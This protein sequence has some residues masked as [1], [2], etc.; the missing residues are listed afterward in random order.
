TPSGV[1]SVTYS[2]VTNTTGT[3]YTAH[4]SLTAGLT[5]TLFFD[6]VLF[7]TKDNIEWSLNFTNSASQS[8]RIGDLAL[9]FPMNTSF[10]TPSTSAMKHSFISG[11]GSYIFWMRPDSVG[12]CLLMAPDDNTKLEFWDTRAPGYEA[13][14]HS[15]VAG[16]NAA[17]QY[18]A[19]ATHGDRWRQ[20]NTSLTLAPGA[21]QTYGVKFQWAND[22][23]AI[24]QTL[25]NEGKIDVH[26]VPGMTVPTNLFAQ[27]ALQTTQAV[28]SVVAEFSE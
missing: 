10:S 17:A 12:P 24:R 21:S 11:Y 4:Y 9:P 28:S 8:V 25:V 15:Y 23:D 18:P 14:I 27:I 2:S 5:G 22:Y 3:K 1:A 7:I 13:F 26:V 6:S 20:P 16:T 19:V